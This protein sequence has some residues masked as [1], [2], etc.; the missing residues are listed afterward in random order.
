MIQ[1]INLDGNAIEVIIPENLTANDFSQLAPLVDKIIN[2]Y[3]KIRLLVDASRFSGWE[4]LD[5]FEHHLTFVKEHQKYIERIAV[6][7]GHNWQNWLVGS[8]RLFVHPD[9]RSFDKNLESD[10]RI[11]LLRS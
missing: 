1:L 10:A 6:L 4:N 7:T 5:A 11:W 2:E 8:V 3:G 9:V